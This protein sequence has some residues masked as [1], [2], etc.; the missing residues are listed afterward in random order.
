MNFLADESVDRLV[1]EHL[2]QEG[3]RVLYI[4][5]LGQGCPMRLS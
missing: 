3:R 5:E 4:A 1:V 2:R